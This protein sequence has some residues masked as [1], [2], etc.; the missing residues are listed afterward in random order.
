ME[1]II[2]NFK[3]YCV[4][5]QNTDEKM[6]NAKKGKPWSEKRRAAYLKKKYNEQIS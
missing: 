2:L 5:N 3:Y 4:A 1:K 6:S